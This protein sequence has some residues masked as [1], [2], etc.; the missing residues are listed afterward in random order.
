MGN[1]EAAIAVDKP[2]RES[3]SSGRHIG[4]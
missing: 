1:S 2:A 3:A 4:I